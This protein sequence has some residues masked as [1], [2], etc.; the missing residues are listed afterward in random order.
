MSMKIMSL[1]KFRN[2]GIT[3]LTLCYW[4]YIIYILTIETRK[5]EYI[6]F[7]MN[8]EFKT[9]F[10]KSNCN[11]KHGLNKP[12]LVTHIAFDDIQIINI[13]EKSKG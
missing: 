12:K 8:I 3:I 7:T 1:R 11:A 6:S 5:Y 2:S 10:A 4:L 13:T 9:Y